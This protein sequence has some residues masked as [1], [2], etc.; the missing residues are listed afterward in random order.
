MTSC[1]PPSPKSHIYCLSPLLPWSSFSEV[2]EVLYLGRSP[3][4]AS[5]KNLTC[6][7][8]A[9]HFLKVE[10]TKVQEQ[11]KLLS[12]DTRRPPGQGW[13]LLKRNPPGVTRAGIGRGLT[14]VLHMP[15]GLLCLLEPRTCECLRRTSQGSGLLECSIW[16]LVPGEETSS[17]GESGTRAVPTSKDHTPCSLWD[18]RLWG[19]LALRVR[20]WEQKLK[21]ERVEVNS[22]PGN[23]FISFHREVSGLSSGH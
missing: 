5:N 2:S 11:M 12:G 7:S 1:I 13:H 18:G 16:S 8:L 20:S 6:N 15:K 21:T 22:H 9:V 19:I 14:S 17:Q 4:S 10:I 23:A 3:H